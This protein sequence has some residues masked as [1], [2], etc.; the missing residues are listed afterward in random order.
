MLRE[1]DFGDEHV[2]IEDRLISASLRA[3]DGAEREQVVNLFTSFALFPEDAEMKRL[4]TQIVTH[5]GAKLFLRSFE[6]VP[7]G[8][9]VRLHGSQPGYHAGPS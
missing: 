3:Y 4:R 5:I 9:A 8:L 6:C 2:K 7:L 1:G